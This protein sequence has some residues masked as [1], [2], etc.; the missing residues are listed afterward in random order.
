MTHRER[1]LR[2]LRYEHV[3]R[4]PYWATGG[5]GQTMRRWHAEGFPEG[6]DLNQY[7][8][9]ERTVGIPVYYGPWPMFPREVIREDGEKEI[10]RNHEG[11]IMQVYKH[12]WDQSMP[13]F[14]EFPVKTRADYRKVI[15]PRLTGPPEDRLPAD[16]KRK[17]ESWKSRTDPLCLFGDRWSGFFGPLRNIMGLENLAMAFYDDPALVEEMMDDICEN[18]LAISARILDDTDID[19]WGFWED[20]GMK[21]GPLLSPTMF[22]KYMVPRYRRVTDFLR[23]RGV[24]YIGVDSDGDVHDLIPHWLHAGLNL[25]WPC[26]IA[27]N[28]EPGPIKKKY[29]RDLT[30]FGGIDKRAIAAG[31]K[32]IDEEL[33]KV[34]PLVAGGGYVPMV[35]HSCPPDISWSNCCYYMEKLRKAIEIA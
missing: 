6:A 20:M 11:I 15:K 18:V 35:D 2:V 32:A 8:G 23:S 34:P 13:H 12:D 19:Y 27:A 17:C 10:V 9:S 1:F 5:W 7:F 16:W 22:R 28:M 24:Q 21:T 30:L 26:E 31:P 4:T 3:D 14:L 29:G 25:L 33:K